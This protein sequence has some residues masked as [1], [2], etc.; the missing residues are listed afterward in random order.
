MKKFGQDKVLFATDWPITRYDRVFQELDEHLKL[1]EP[2]K[3]KFMH[4]NA[5]KAFKLEG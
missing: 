3:S 4:E 5:L 2:V 1:E